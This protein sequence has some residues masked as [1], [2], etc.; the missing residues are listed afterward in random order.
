MREHFKM[1][2]PDKSRRG[3]N[4]ALLMHFSSKFVLFPL[5]ITSIIIIAIIVIVKFLLIGSRIS[6]SNLQPTKKSQAR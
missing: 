6:H 5:I 1:V 2:L 3:A 4:I